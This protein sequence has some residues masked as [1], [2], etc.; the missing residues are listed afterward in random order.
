MALDF[1]DKI[2]ENRIREAH[3]SGEFEGLS[4][5]GRPLV[6]DDELGVSDDPRLAFKILKNANCLPPEIELRRDIVCLRDLLRTIEDGDRSTRLMRDVN[7]KILRLTLMRSTPLA[8][9]AA[10]LY[11]GKMLGPE[12][13]STG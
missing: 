2:V 7:M 12:S 8:P 10:Q 5:Q 3:R 1:F 4:G 6:F 11:I 13:T 9:E